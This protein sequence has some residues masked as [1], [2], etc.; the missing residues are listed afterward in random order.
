MRSGILTAGGERRNT[1]PNRPYE[2]S[3]EKVSLLGKIQGLVDVG[4][5]QSAISQISSTPVLF[6][7]AVCSYLARKKSWTKNIN[8]SWRKLIFKILVG[9]FLW[10]FRFPRRN[11]KH[12][13]KIRC[14]YWTFHW[15]AGGMCEILKF[16]KNLNQNFEKPFLSWKSTIFCSGFFSWQDMIILHRKTPPTLSLFDL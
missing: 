12:F 10:I 7:D 2:A 1:A 5:G 9:F 14:L 15:K 4:P 16:L 6:S 8:Y 3:R 11:C 13:K